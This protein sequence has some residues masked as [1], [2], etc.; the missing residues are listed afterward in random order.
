MGYDDSCQPVTTT[1]QEYLLV[2]ATELPRIQTIYRDLLKNPIGVNWCWAQAGTIPRAWL[3][4]ALSPICIRQ[5][6]ILPEALF[7][8]VEAARRGA[9][10]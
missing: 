3:L 2:T 7:T 9:A 4:N 8:L 6:P 5:T 1:F 10:S